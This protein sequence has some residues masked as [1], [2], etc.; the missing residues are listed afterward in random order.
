MLYRDNRPKEAKDVPNHQPKK[1]KSRTNTLC[2]RY[3]LEDVSSGGVWI[4]SFK[5]QRGEPIEIFD[6]EVIMLHQ[7]SDEKHLLLQ[8]KLV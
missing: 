3:F 4:D 7:P 8:F 1:K 2:D 6:G 5:I